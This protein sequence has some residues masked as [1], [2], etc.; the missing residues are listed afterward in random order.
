LQ[1]YQGYG[2]TETSPVVSVNRPG[3]NKLGSV[4]PALPGAEIKI[5]EDGEI[6]LKGPM[7][8]KG[9]WNKP[10]ETREV[11]AEDGWLRTG[12]IGYLDDEG[13]LFITDR[14]KEIIVTSGGKNIAPTRIE[15]SFNMDPMI[16]KVVVVGN[17][18]KFLSALVCP[19]FEELDRWAA[20]RNIP[21]E[22]RSE[23]VRHP[24]V[25]EIYQGSV[26][27]VNAQLARFETI[28]KFAVMDHVFTEETGELTATHKVKRR[29]VDEMYRKIVNGFYE[30]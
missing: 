14:K 15:N 26:N 6:L 28:K 30:E 17:N 16:E 7:V 2:L 27:K 8:M 29:N 21:T 9:Y 10:E 11:L 4:G 5:A 1:L 18:R 19:N 23:L 20:A 25:M 13:Y 22:P 3:N 24:Q 12:D